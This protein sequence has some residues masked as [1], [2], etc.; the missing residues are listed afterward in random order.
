MNYYSFSVGDPVKTSWAL[1][2]I[3]KI[4][5]KREKTEGMPPIFYK[6]FPIANEE[7]RL[8]PQYQHLCCK[9]CG[10]YD[11]DEIFNVGFDDPV[12]IRFKGDFGH[13]DDRVFAVSEKFL[14]I[15]MGKTVGGY[16]TKPLGK[17]GWHAL[18]ATLRV[19]HSDKVLKCGKSL[20]SE[21]R[22]PDDAFGVFDQLRQLFLPPLR[23]TFFTTK[24][25]WPR[26][27]SD[28]DFFITEDVLEALKEGG[29]AGGYCN[30][31]WTT[32]DVKKHKE[33]AKQGANYWRPPPVPLNGKRGKK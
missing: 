33:R 6:F 15:L 5:P 12:T 9:T 26:H 21:C 18:N 1:H 11:D 2:E 14:K 20:C 8:K 27:G 29:I 10:R 31:L 25:G 4:L 19:D 3:V 32:D 28:R 23:N 22:R 7:V 30:R 16:E 13:T 17:S 24:T